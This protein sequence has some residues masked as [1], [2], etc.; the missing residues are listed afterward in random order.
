MVTL[1]RQFG[2]LQ[3]LKCYLQKYFIHKYKWD[4][5]TKA[6]EYLSTRARE[7]KKYKSTRVKEY[8]SIICQQK[9]YNFTSF[10]IV[11]NLKG[12]ILNYMK[13]D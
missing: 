6:H 9:M 3:L 5:N 10:L 13:C 2:R 4:T 12:I 7:K 11:Q 8:K 1:L